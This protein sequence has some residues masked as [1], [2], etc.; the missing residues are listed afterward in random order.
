[1]HESRGLVA[2]KLSP[3]EVRSVVHWKLTIFKA[4]IMMKRCFKNG[5]H[6]LHMS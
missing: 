3:N 2:A 5:D 4:W 1:M 6:L